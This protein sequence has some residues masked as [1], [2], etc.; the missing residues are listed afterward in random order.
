MPAKN[1]LKKISALVY[2]PY[3][4]FM[5]LKGHVLD[6]HLLIISY[7]SLYNQILNPPLNLWDPM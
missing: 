1:L 2:F 3:E 5:N 7:L 6:V 4:I